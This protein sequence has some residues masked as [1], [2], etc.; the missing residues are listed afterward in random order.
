MP[1]RL[2]NRSFPHSVPH[3][4]N[5][6]NISQVG[7]IVPFRLNNGSPCDNNYLGVIANSLLAALV[8]VLCPGTTEKRVVDAH[9]TLAA[10][11]PATLAFSAHLD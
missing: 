5:K 6:K 3:V 7:P 11:L 2:F 10:L 9:L 4:L 1:E 8:L